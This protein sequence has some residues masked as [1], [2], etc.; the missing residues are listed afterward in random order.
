M[1]PGVVRVK[2]QA[3]LGFTGSEPTEFLEP[4]QQDTDIVTALLKRLT[5]KTKVLIGSGFRRRACHN[6]DMRDNAKSRNAVLTALNLVEEASSAKFFLGD[7][8]R[9][10]AKRMF[11]SDTA[12]YES[13]IRRLGFR[14]LGTVLDA[15]CGY[16]QWSFA[17]AE[18]N[19]HVLSIDVSSERVAFV[20]EVLARTGIENMVASS[21]NLSELT[22]DSETIDGI[23]SYGVVFCTP[24]RQT[25]AAFSRVLKPGGYLYFNA[26]SIDWF[27]YL[28]RTRHN[29]CSDYKPREVVAGALA[30][31]L[32]YERGER[33]WTGQVVMDPEE[34]VQEL[35][36]LGFVQIEWGWEGSLGAG[37]VSEEFDIDSARGLFE[38]R[39][40]KAHAST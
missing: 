12:T 32:L 23:F 20:C 16:G 31:S 25:L 11:S 33:D 40:M 30:N 4:V 35:S 38:V 8:D 34:T 27:S 24:W 10:F 26:T 21:S 7:N 29:E 19:S 2:C 14:D 18:V 1:N 13:S 9:A 39:C 36:T 17:L 6:L 3:V 22:L 5:K 37:E 28:W 15:G